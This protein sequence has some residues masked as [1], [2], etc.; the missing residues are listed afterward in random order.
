MRE[1]HVKVG[2]CR[3][4]VWVVRGALF[5]NNVYRRCVCGVAVVA[6][7]RMKKRGL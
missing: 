2:L 5:S 3:R 4:F 1:Y 7:F 6:A